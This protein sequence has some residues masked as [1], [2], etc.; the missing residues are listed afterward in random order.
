[1]VKQLMDMCIGCIAQNLHAISNVGKHLP[2]LHKEKILQWVVDHN[3]LTAQYLPHVT[4]HL[5]SPVL[6]SISFNECEQITDKLLVQ[7]D[8]C[9]CNLESIKIEGCK[10]TDVGVSALLSHQ[11]EL[12]ILV[13][14]DVDEMTGTGLEVLRSKKL[15]E[16]DL[17]Q[18]TNLINKSLVQLVTRN[19]T[20]S[21]LNLGS[22]YKITHE[23]IPTI[24]ATLSHELE[25]LDLSSIHTIE[26]E[27]LVVLSQ[28][29]K[30]LQGIVLH[31]CNRVTRTGIMALNRE[32]TKLQLLDVSFCY[33]LQESSNKDCLTELPVSLKNLVLSGLQLDGGDIHATV[34][35][36]PKLDTLRLCG[37][38]SITEESAV[39]IFETVGPQLISLDMTGCHQ[40]MTDDILRL[41]V[42][43]CKA[44]EEICLAFCM[45]LTGEPLRMLFRDAERSGNLTLFR[46]SG[47]KDLYHDILLDM[48]KACVNL[49]RLYMAGI[50]SV[51]DTLLFSIANHMPHLKNISL[52]SCVGTVADQVTD[53]GVVELTRCCPLEDICLAGIHSI[54]DKSVFALANNCPDLKTL[55]VSGCTKVTTQ[56]TNYLQD[57]CNDKVYVYH[58]LPNADPNL[59]MAK[60]LDTGEFCQVDQTKWTMW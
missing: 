60:N 33:K 3:M 52:K 29:C 1:M 5:F 7:L 51:D 15:K 35:R 46:V 38:N 20:I 10:A 11:V 44:L 36:L 28:H 49:T 9:K 41:I 50:K 47:C 22:C 58:R 27:D 19:P 37:I 32:C 21:R 59:V 23:V 57:V 42:K 16:V 17:S 39:K 12:Q 14:K 48:S 45:K 26:D 8:A 13:L 43:N 4:Y 53:N 54:T 40:I 6:R 31:G 25:H 55:F 56:A 34:S 24:A 2:T 30:N 18:C